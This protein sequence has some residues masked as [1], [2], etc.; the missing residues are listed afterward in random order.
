MLLS[1]ALISSSVASNIRIH[2]LATAQVL[3]KLSTT[4]TTCKLSKDI[5]R[6][7]EFDWLE[8]VY[9]GQRGFVARTGALSIQYAQAPKIPLFRLHLG[10][11]AISMTAQVRDGLAQIVEY[12][13]KAIREA[14]EE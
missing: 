11:V 5:V 1:D 2:P 12:L 3:D 8:I 6:I 10:F 7:D 9:R 4:P 14:P 13:L